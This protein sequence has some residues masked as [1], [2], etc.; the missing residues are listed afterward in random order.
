MNQEEQDRLESISQVSLYSA[1][2]NS[3]TVQ[4]S[5]KIAER[6][7]T[8]ET[9]LEMGPAEGVMTELLATT[10]KKLTLVE[11]SGQF[12]EDLRRRFPKA[13]VVHSLFEEFDSAEK[14]DNIILGHVLEH[15]QDP[16]DILARARH[17][18]KPDT[19]RLFA[20]VPNSH[21]LHR[22]AAV[23]MG[24]LPQEDALN[25]MDIHHGHRRVFDP[26]SFRNAFYQAKLE[27]EVFGG[28]WMK[29]VSNKQIEEHWTP[30]MLD[31]FMKLGERYPDI[32]G[33]IYVVA[34][35]RNTRG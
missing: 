29:P 8:G 9:L 6:F 11:G 14:F 19:G 3:A 31:A 12:C 26:A 21:S 34:R 24:M 16:V 25:E 1:G 30:E 17:W 15:V 5:F 18:L 10:R 7:L 20:A 23:I 27:I 2:A 13:N 28:Y 22:Q 32:A 33:E 35:N 4:Y